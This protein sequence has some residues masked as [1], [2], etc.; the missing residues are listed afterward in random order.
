MKLPKIETRLKSQKT[1]DSENVVKGKKRAKT[2]RKASSSTNTTKCKSC[3]ELGHGSK[4]SP[5]CP[6]HEGTLEETITRKLGSFES[7]HVK[8][9]FIVNHYILTYHKHVTNALFEQNFWYTVCRVVYGSA[10]IEDVEA[11]YP[12][13]TGFAE[14]YYTLLIHHH[15]V[16]LSVYCGY[17]A[18]YGQIVSSA[19]ITLA[20]TYENYYVENFEDTVAKYFIYY[21]RLHYPDFNVDP[22]KDLVYNQLLDYILLQPAGQLFNINPTTAPREFMPFITEMEHP[23]NAASNLIRNRLPTILANKSNWISKLYKLQNSGIVGHQFPARL[24]PTKFAMFPNPSMKWRFIKLDSQNLHHFFPYDRLTKLDYETEIDYISRFFRYFSFIIFKIDSIEE[25]IN[26]PTGK[27]KMFINCIYNGGY[28]CRIAFAR[29]TTSSIIGNVQLSI[30]DFTEEEICAVDPGRKN[31]FVSYHGGTDVRKCS[32]RECC[33]SIGY[34]GRMKMEEELKQQQG[35]KTIE[36][37]I[38]S[39]YGYRTAELNWKI[40]CGRQV[41]L[42]YATTTLLNGGKKYNPQK[43]SRHM[44]KK[45]H[46]KRKKQN[47]RRNPGIA[48]QSVNIMDNHHTYKRSFELGDK[49]KMPLVL[50]GDGLTNGAIFWNRD[51]MAAQNMYH[52]AQE[53]WAGHGRPDP[54]CR[55][56]QSATTNVV[57]FPR[58]ET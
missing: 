24:T 29:K 34:K 9:Q 7:G 12:E 38:P 52:I 2:K 17:L 8:A 55:Q 14:A 20:T 23:L 30:Y 37:L 40:F 3:G 54:F 27:N 42:E 4:R 45:S 33:Q 6:N 49:S 46:K 18:Y 48:H 16:N 25:F 41:S 5:L 35:I 56:S 26:L 1:K 28:T 21:L 36:S 43:R 57:V 13:M 44:S 53:V 31:A 39:F 51:V 22:I 19:S 11:R 50:F 15:E 32:T 10:R 58:W 47:N